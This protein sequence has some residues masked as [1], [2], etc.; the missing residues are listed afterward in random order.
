MREK[1]E[2]KTK[3][4]R[5]TK[6]YFER[7]QTHSAS[8]RTRNLENG[9]KSWGGRGDHTDAIKDYLKEKKNHFVQG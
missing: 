6:I 3:G 9:E 5:I 7:A 2:S 4:G 1:E 8:A